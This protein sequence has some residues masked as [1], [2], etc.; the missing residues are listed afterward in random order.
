MDEQHRQA[1]EHAAAIIEL[2]AERSPKSGGRV[3]VDEVLWLQALQ[4]AAAFLIAS[5]SPE[6][7]KTL[8]SDFGRDLGKKIQAAAD[9]STPAEPSK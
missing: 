2:I 3:L 1:A 8:F 9:P 4:N 6:Q 7:Q 5:T